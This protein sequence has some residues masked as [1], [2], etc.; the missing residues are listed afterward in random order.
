MSK[1]ALIKSNVY[2]TKSII[3][4]QYPDSAWDFVSGDPNAKSE[5]IKEMWASVPWLYAGVN[6]ISQTAAEIPIA[7][8]RGNTEVA[9]NEDWQDPTGYLPDISKLMRKISASLVLEGQGYLFRDDAATVRATKRLIFWNPTTVKLNNKLTKSQRK[10]YFDRTVD[11]KTVTYT[12]EQVIYFWPDDG[13]TEVGP[14]ASSPAK[15]ALSAAGVL[16]NADEYVKAYFDRGAVR[17][18]MLAVEGTPNADDK[19]KLADWWKTI[20]GG[21]KCFT[22]TIP[23]EFCRLAEFQ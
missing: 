1:T 17:A 16:Y 7:L 5:S 23:I 22:S 4:D 18:M 2:G 6:I 21:V 3:F 14:P 19:K 20:T 12:D 9:S 8:Y 10:L 11:G 13:Y 15:A